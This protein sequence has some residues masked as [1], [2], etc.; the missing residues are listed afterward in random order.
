MG[1][2]GFHGST[3]CNFV[4]WDTHL[5]RPAQMTGMIAGR[6]QNGAVLQQDA[7]PLSLRAPDDLRFARHE[8]LRAAP[9]EAK[10][11]LGGRFAF[12]R[13]RESR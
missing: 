13:S 9:L 11:W 3:E 12:R 5:P 4:Q 7:C 8:I 6:R 1:K 10:E 2:D